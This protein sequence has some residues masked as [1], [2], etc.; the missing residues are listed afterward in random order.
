MRLLVAEDD[1]DLA[2]LLE[3]GFKEEGY[4]VDVAGDGETAV[5]R[6]TGVEYDVLVLDI[7]LPDFDGIEVL[8]RV[9]HAGRTTPVIFLTARDG[10]LDRVKGLDAGADDYLVKPFAWDE[11]AARVRALLRRGTPN[12]DGAFRHKDIELDPV[13]RVVRL[14]EDRTIDLTS[15]E[16][17]LLHLLIRDPQKVFTRTEI[18]EHL[19][20]DEWEGLSNVIDVFVARVRKKLESAGAAASIDTIRGVGYRMNGDAST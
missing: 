13:R 10:L 14:G 11:L 19:Y 6:A 17:D 20:D 5:W 2:E 8:R 18:I 12:V 9:R 3:R 1:V 4:A 15:K 7:L 16:F